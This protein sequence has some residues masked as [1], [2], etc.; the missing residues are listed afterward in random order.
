[1]GKTQLAFK[2]QEQHRPKYSFVFWIMSADEETIIHSFQTIARGLVSGVSQ[3]FPKASPEVVA[4]SLGIRNVDA[5]DE[6]L[7][8]FKDARA[9]N[10]IDA[11]KIFL[12]RED[13]KNWHLIFDSWDFTDG[14]NLSTFFPSCSHG[15]ILITTR[16]KDFGNL[17]FSL[18]VSGVGPDAGARLLLNRISPEAS[19]T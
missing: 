9:A 3:L 13:N 11:V 14:V 15:H 12:A 5:L 16:Q 6:T 2:Y 10:L 18:N 8:T 17:G 1:M 4:R 19:C 7:A